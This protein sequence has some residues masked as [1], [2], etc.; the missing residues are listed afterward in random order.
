VG[1]RRQRDDSAKLSLNVRPGTIRQRA[2]KRVSQQED[3]TLPAERGGV[4]N[5]R[6]NILLDVILEVSGYG[7]P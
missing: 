1:R 4:L 2:A 3:A 5:E 7:A 6:R